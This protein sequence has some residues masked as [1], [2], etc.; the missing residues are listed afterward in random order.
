MNLRYVLQRLFQSALGVFGVLVLVFVVTHLLG[1]PVRIALPGNSP[2]AMIA[3]TRERLGLNDP[4]LVQFGNFLWSAA[5]DSFGQSY[6]RYEPALQVVLER[7]PATLY[8]TV[9]A[10]VVT[11]PLGIGLGILA[12]LRPRSVLARAIDVF[13]FAS[14]S[15]VG[16]WLA[17][18]LILVFSVSLRVVPVSGYGGVDHVILPAL[19]LALLQFGALAQVTR[20]TLAEELSKSYVSAARARGISERRV[21]LGHALRNALIPI[22]TFCGLILLGLLGGSIIIETVFGWPGVGLLLIQAISRRDLPLIYASVFVTAV[23][24]LLVNLVVDLLYN[25]LNPRVR[26]S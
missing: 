20:A 5:F 24:V 1:D 3:A 8:L 2:P 4:I 22:V 23:L 19:T 18:M 16:F 7:V 14:A 26:V 15:V 11:L 12:A 10:L 13:S 9:A 25:K 21:I 6:W 17:L